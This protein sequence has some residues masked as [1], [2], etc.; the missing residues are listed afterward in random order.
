MCYY[1]DSD[2]S[3]G[4]RQCIVFKWLGGGA[5]CGNTARQAVSGVSRGQ[6]SR[7]GVLC[8][9]ECFSARLQHR[10]PKRWVGQ[11]SRFGFSAVAAAGPEF[12]RRG[13]HSASADPIRRGG[14][15]P[16]HTGRFDHFGRRF[17]RPLVGSGRN[18]QAIRPAAN[19]CF[20][21]KRRGRPWNTFLGQGL[22]FWKHLR[23]LLYN[24]SYT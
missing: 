20:P 4:C 5:K 24:S 18:R 10:P 8:M 3:F 16:T 15:R 13:P 17:R 21:R 1:Q 12:G 22:R 23:L 6:F 9:W 19:L 14:G 11:P 2:L 7:E